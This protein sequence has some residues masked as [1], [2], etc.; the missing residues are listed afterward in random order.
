MSTS[1][2]I[3]YSLLGVNYIWDS[4]TGFLSAGGF[5]FYIVLAILIGVICLSIAFV[6]GVFNIR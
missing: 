6:R 2:L 1:T 4:V 5:V 3:S